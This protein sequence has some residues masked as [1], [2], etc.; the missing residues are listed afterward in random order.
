MV[1]QELLQG[2]RYTVSNGGKKKSQMMHHFK[3]VRS[4]ELHASFSSPDAIETGSYACKLNSKHVWE[5]IGQSTLRWRF[6]WGFLFAFF[7]A[8]NMALSY[9]LT[10]SDLEK[11]DD[12]FNL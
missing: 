1:Q 5:F 10:K 6:C 4:E 12:F 8:I 11:T 9:C 3:I 2:G 7:K